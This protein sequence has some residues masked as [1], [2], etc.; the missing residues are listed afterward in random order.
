MNLNQ[1]DDAVINM[2]YILENMFLVVYNALV[3]K[4]EKLSS[5]S[6]FLKDLNLKHKT[7]CRR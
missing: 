3:L 1:T 6:E 2:H 4:E 7:M 5:L